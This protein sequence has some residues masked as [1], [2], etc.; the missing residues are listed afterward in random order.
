MVSQKQGLILLRLFGE[1]I[2]LLINIF[3]NSATVKRRIFDINCS[4]LS[5]YMIFIGIFNAN[6]IEP[7]KL[8]KI[9]PLDIFFLCV[10]IDACISAIKVDFSHLSTIN[11]LHN[12]FFSFAYNFIVAIPAGIAAMVI[13]V[14][15]KKLVDYIKKNLINEVSF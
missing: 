1:K 10:G 4:Y 9:S 5:D 6:L 8:K 12:L 15:G 14:F 7:Q 13:M 3:Y 11:I 2:P